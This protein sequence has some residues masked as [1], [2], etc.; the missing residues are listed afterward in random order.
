METQVNLFQE[1]IEKS[2]KYLIFLGVW[3]TSTNR[4]IFLV[5]FIVL[6]GHII[7][8][9][10]KNVL[11]PERESIENAFTMANGSFMYVVYFIT[12]LYKKDKLLELLEYL[13]SKKRTLTSEG[14]KNLMI[15]G[16]KE[17]Q[18]I[19]TVY[20][21][22][23]ISAILVRFVQPPLK[24]VFFQIF[25]L[26]KSVA[27][28]PPMGV[29]VFIFGDIATYIIESLIRSIMLATLIGVCS[30]YILATLYIC[31]QYNILA[32]EL[33]NFNYDN[34]EVIK[35]MI[36]DHQ[37]ILGFTK[38]LIE[39]FSPFFFADC[40]LSFINLSI[41]LFSLIE[42]NANITN[43]LVEG[44]LVTV[45]VTQL[46][47]I[48]YFGDRLLDAVSSASIFFENYLHFFRNFSFYQRHRK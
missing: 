8:V 44:P 28:A 42:S 46:F 38:K 22:I 35:R 29:P 14:S 13:K 34:D 17:Y 5:N 23:L 9:V 40:V 21:Y 7:L 41:M 11:N 3:P 48:L 27:L 2:E 1:L 30:L 6:L 24:Y 19:S 15:A 39:I 20:L 47:L 37:K 31:T 43:Y 4:W 32:H 10:V 26:E 18:K 25:L 36:G 12:L 33:E 45:G 16:G